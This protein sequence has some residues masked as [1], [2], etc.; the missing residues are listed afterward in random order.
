MTEGAARRI[1]AATGLPPCR[2]VIL[3]HVERA[4][5]LL[6]AGDDLSLA[7]VV[8]CAGFP[9]QSK[10]TSPRCQAALRP[11]SPKYHKAITIEMKDII[12]SIPELYYYLAYVVALL[13]TALWAHEAVPPVSEPRAATL[14]TRR[15]A[16]D[17][18]VAARCNFDRA[19][20]RSSVV[21][22]RHDR[23]PFRDFEAALSASYAAKL[24]QALRT[25]RIGP[26]AGARPTDRA[27]G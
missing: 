25:I 23:R 18:P 14:K 22:R 5:Y 17:V 2:Y 27:G 13:V 9:D 11:H 4:K 1:K 26:S 20:L 8:A 15:R 24:E 12:L 16:G 6:Q 7:E 10:S 3:C 19:P 21:Q